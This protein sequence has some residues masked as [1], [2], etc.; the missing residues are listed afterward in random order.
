LASRETEVAASDPA[1]DV[2][3][4]AKVWTRPIRLGAI[5]VLGADRERPGG[6]DG[7]SH[8]KLAG[9]RSQWEWR[10]LALA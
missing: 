4:A 3:D 1:D 10:P 9:H 8:G 2:I 6:D 5:G 7:V